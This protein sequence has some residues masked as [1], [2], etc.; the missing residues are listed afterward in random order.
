MKIFASKGYQETY[1]TVSKSKLPN[2]DFRILVIHM[3][4]NLYL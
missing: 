3:I 1:I 2:S 4:M